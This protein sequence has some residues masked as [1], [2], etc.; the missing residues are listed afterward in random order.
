M[1]VPKKAFHPT[2]AIEPDNTPHKS[3]F[4]TASYLYYAAYQRHGGRAAKK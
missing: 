1:G 4:F 2:I 3:Q